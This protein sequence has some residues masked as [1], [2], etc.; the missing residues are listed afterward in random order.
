MYK[1]AP[2]LYKCLR[3]YTD[4]PNSRLEE[5]TTVPQSNVGCPSPQILAH[6]GGLLLA[7]LIQSKPPFWGPGAQ[8]DTYALIRFVWPQAHLFG[9]PNDEAMNGH[10]LY[11]KGLHAYSCYQVFNSPW[12]RIMEQRNSVHPAHRPESFKDLVHYIFTFHD[13]T[14]ECVAKSFEV[15][16]LSLQEQVARE[17]SNEFHPAW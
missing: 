4:D 12:I 3:M 2:K 14:F 6:E 15:K 10:P 7:Y 9:P 1:G 8:P 17:F 5:I 13:S 11:V 16:I